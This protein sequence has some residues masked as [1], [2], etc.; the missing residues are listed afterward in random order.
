MD[1]KTLFDPGECQL[2]QSAFEGLFVKTLKLDDAFAQELRQAGY[3]VSRQQPQYPSSVFKRCME[4]AC[5][6]VYPT[7]PE[8]EAMRL[9]SA[10]LLD[11]F[12]D[13]IVGR[14]VKAALP[15]LSPETFLKRYPRFF[16]MAA[17]GVKMTVT[18]EAP[19]RWRMELRDRAPLPHFNAGTL[20]CTLER[21]G[22]KP[23]VQVVE[24]G[25]WH[26]MLSISW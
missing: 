5:R 18:E 20:A 8:A 19:R 13:T 4:I 23:E 16:A 15:F 9:I 2:Q 11:G 3:D 12:F 24:Q 14:A 6:R 1:A 21:F 22:V 26:F 10:Q 25:T 7:R 17:P